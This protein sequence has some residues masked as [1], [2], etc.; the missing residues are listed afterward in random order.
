MYNNKARK[1]MNGVSTDGHG[2]HI[3]PFQPIL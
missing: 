1:G 2:C 3:L